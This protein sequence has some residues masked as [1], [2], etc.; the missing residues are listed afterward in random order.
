MT[1]TERK[2]VTALR[3]IMR[4]IIQTVNE[5]STTADLGIPGTYMWLPLEKVLNVDQFTQ[6]MGYLV[7]RGYVI[8]RGDCY[9]P[10]TKAVDF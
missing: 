5:A 6:I 2:K 4:A 7:D 3:E 8:K 10:G 1:T 9:H